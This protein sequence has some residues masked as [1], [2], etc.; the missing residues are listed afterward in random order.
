MKGFARLL[1]NRI[2]TSLKIWFHP[3]FFPPTYVIT[4]IQEKVIITI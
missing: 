2:E 3:F 1:P 4:A